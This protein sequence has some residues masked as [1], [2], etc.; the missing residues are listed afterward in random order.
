MAEALGGK[1]DHLGAHDL[2]IWQPILGRSFLKLTF[3]DS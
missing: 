3:F 2:K 1:P